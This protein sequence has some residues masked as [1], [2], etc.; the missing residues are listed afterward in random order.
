MAGK[1]KRK[2]AKNAVTPDGLRFPSR[3]VP[4]AVLGCILSENWSDLGEKDGEF[5]CEDR[6]VYWRDA[7]SDDQQRREFSYVGDLPSGWDVADLHHRETGDSGLFVGLAADIAEAVR[8]Q[9]EI[10]RLDD[11]IGEMIH[12]AV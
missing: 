1:T 5:S 11:A 3:L 8:M 9:K 4:L 6:K 10:W 2:T 12:S 7:P